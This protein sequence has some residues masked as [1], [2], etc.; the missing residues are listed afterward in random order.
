MFVLV[1]DCKWEQ[2]LDTLLALAVHMGL[3]ELAVHKDQQVLAASRP[4][5]VRH[6]TPIVP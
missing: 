5:I 4:D 2:V 1:P 6:S 3:R